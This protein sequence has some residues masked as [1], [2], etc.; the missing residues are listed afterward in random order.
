[1][2]ARFKNEK[3]KRSYLKSM[4]E[5]RGYAPATIVAIER[6]I[7]RWEE[8]SENEDYGRFTAKKAV[9][10][11]K[12][13][14]EAG[15]GGKPL[16]ANSRYHCLHHLKQFFGWL[17]TQPGYRSKISADAISYLTLDRKTVRSISSSS[18]P[19]WPTLEYVKALVVSIDP[20]TEL[21][22]RDRA[23]I[24]FLLLSGMRDKAVA[25]LPLGC[26]DPE[27]LEVQQRPTAGVDT[28]FGKSFKTVL[29]PFDEI[30][31]EVVKDWCHYLRTERLFSDSDPMFP[32]T[33]V[34]Q[35][36]HNLSF[37]RAGVEPSFWGGTGSIR[38]ILKLR[39]H[40]AGLAYYYPHS[41]RHAHVHLAM[42]SARSAEE[43]RAISQNIGHENIGTTLITYGKLDEYR[44]GEVVRRLDLRP[45]G[46]DDLTES[47]RQAI[48]KLLRRRGGIA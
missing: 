39:A 42:R 27:T 47:E 2:N 31:L 15:T 6:A 16:S 40:R 23:L 44:V 36:E 8:F 37:E 24:A 26:F 28:K 20:V 34:K 35:A 45:G 48:E 19:K 46:S 3:V 14:E 30:L 38:D 9:A 10:F 7:S 41:F 22:R 5:A 12:Y 11:K 32:Q 29:L 13:L 4:R 43:I 33:K 1:M 17:S 21:D 18:Q 25:T